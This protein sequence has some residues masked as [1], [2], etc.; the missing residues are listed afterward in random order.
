MIAEVRE[1]RRA[2]GKRERGKETETIR[3][4]RGRERGGGE[5]RGREGG[6]E[7]K[8]GREQVRN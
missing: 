4:W 6:G 3:V 1:S 7:S 5:E 2:R 8:R